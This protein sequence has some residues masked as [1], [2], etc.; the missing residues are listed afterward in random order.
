MKA[1]YQTFPGVYFHSTRA[2]FLVMCTSRSFEYE[3]AINPG[4]NAG[5]LIRPIASVQVAYH[6]HC[7][8]PVRHLENIGI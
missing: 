6:C 4:G 8:D 2:Q 5:F 3:K 1:L 7:H